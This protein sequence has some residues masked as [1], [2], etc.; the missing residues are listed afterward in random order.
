MRLLANTTISLII[1][2]IGLLIAYEA[3]DYVKPDF[4]RGY[5]LDKKYVFQGVFPIGLYVH[6]VVAPISLIIGTALI[7][8]RLEKYK[9]LH[10]FLGYNYAILSLFVT[11]SG[12]ILAFYAFG[13]VISK[14]NFLLL[15]VLFGWFVFK[16]YTSIKEKDIPNH[17]RFITRSYILILSAVNLRLFSFL[18]INILELDGKLMYTIIGLLSWMPWLM[19][20]ETI[21]LF[22]R[23]KQS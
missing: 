21:L 19:I 9:K 2:L 18:F 5:L 10:R 12:I 4:T 16:A 13:G 7:F 6:I 11:T 15:S 22:E 8:F 14:I 17:R 20:Y 3:I 1:L 23:N